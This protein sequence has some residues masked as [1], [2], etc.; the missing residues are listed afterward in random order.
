MKRS[1]LKELINEIDKELIIAEGIIDSL[2]SLFLSPKIKRDVNLL[3]GSP[4]WI[5]IVHKLNTTRDEMEQYNKRAE[6]Y[7]KRCK[8]TVAA[9]RKAGYKVDN[10]SDLEGNIKLYKKRNR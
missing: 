6:E 3:K 2:I 10:C 1:K 5:E 7:L 4:E 9:A 8:E